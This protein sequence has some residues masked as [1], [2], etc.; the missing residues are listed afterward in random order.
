MATLKSQ[1]GVF[2]CAVTCKRLSAVCAVTCM[3]LSAPVELGVTEEIC[4]EECLVPFVESDAEPHSI[5]EPTEH[6]LQ[7]KASIAGWNKLRKPL[8]LTAVETS[9][10]PVDQICFFVVK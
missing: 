7:S 9:A 4:S 2:A 1:C 8:I 10:M 6:E 3:S 5:S